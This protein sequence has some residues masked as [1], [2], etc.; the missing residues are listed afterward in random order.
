[1]RVRDGDRE[2]DGMFIT[3]VEGFT[4]PITDSYGFEFEFGYLD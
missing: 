2:V 3:V 1:M 4:Y